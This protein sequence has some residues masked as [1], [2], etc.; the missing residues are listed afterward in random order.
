MDR[1]L[2]D[3]SALSDI[4]Q[5]AAKRSPHVA[6]HLRSYLRAHGRVTIS[7]ISCYEVLRGLR[8]K[9]ATMQIKRFEEFCQ[10]SELLPITYA[11]LDR[12]ASL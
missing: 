8:K 7:E 11:V 9:H 3:T 6:Q 1:C 10:R 4:I 12:A 2:L 5:P